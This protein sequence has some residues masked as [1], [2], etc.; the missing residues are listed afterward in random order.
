M[1]RKWATEKDGHGFYYTNDGLEQLNVRL[2]HVPVVD[3]SA[4]DF[5]WVPYC[6][7]ERVPGSCYT[8]A[9]AQE[10]AEDYWRVR[11]CA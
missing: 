6:G 11:A 3:S 7:G 9:K 2:E 1:N 10:A 8:K 4:A 5:K